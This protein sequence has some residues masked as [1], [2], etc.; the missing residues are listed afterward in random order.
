MIFFVIR[1]CTLKL[2]EDKKIKKN[3]IAPDSNSR[4][5]P[6]RILTWVVLVT[7]LVFL[8]LSFGIKNIPKVSLEDC[9]TTDL[10]NL[11]GK[12]EHYDSN[13]FRLPK[14]GES[15]TFTVKIPKEAK[16]IGHPV[17]CFFNYNSV[18]TVKY[19]GDVIFTQGQEKQERNYTTGHTMVRAALPDEPEGIITVEYLQQEDNTLADL[20]G[21]LLMPAEYSWLYPVADISSQ[22]SLLL[23]VVFSV[24]SLQVAIFNTIF[25]TGKGAAI[26]GFFLSLF[27]ISLTIWAMGYTG[28]IFALTNDDTIIP[29]AEYMATYILPVWFNAYLLTGAASYGWRKRVCIVLE[30]FYVGLF[31]VA[32]LIHLFGPHHD[33]YLRLL[34]CDYAFLLAGGLFFM[35]LVFKD[36]TSVSKF[37]KIGMFVM[38]IL[39][40]IEVFVSMLGR[41]IPD[42]LGRI[43]TT[44]AVT[45]T[46]VLVF[47][48]ALLSD[49]G[50]R[51]YESFKEQEE[52][53]RL[54]MIAYTDILTGLRNRA[55]FDEKEEPYLSSKGS[56]AIAFI[57]ADGLKKTND[58]YGHKAGDT[59]LKNVGTAIR[60]GCANSHCRGFRYGGDEFLIVGGSKE[61]VSNALAKMKEVLASTDTS[62]SVGLSARDKNENISVSEV[63][64]K[65]DSAMYEEKE[66]NHKRRED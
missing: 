60:K 41:F 11:E 40:F 42:I 16:T 38:L 25:N 43:I 34:S 20:T 58:L 27:C 54:E 55:S 49:Y 15:L 4:Y 21:L 7:I 30:V 14:K 53:E 37:F 57:D 61:N 56:F 52:V 1:K 50:S 10:T 31:S 59:L 8:F 3:N 33:G 45:P 28:T 63:I 36:R 23:F 39:A 44:Q 51:V 22:V 65:A 26:Q 18:I 24:V 5:I 6:V 48:L 13:H 46:I 19:N 64:K 12:V 62:V 17:L 66:K 2:S 9:I 29:Y 32:T 35:F 47:Q